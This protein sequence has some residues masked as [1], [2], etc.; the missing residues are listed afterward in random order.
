MPTTDTEES[1]AH[2]APLKKKTNTNVNSTHRLL[3]SENCSQLR[4]SSTGLKQTG[5]KKTKTNQ[6]LNLVSYL[7]ALC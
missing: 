1:K 3:D 4:Q 5:T 6:K 7:T 2:L